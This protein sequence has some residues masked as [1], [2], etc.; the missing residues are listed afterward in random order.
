[1][2]GLTRKETH[3]IEELLLEQRKASLEEAELELAR[4]HDEAPADIVG[5]VAD[6]GDQASAMLLT[7]LNNTMARRHLDEVG[8][9]DAAL[10]HLRGHSFGVCADCGSEIPY[11]RLQA[12][13]TATRCTAC[14]SQ[15]EHLFA[16]GATPTL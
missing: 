11:A 16:H 10:A 1:M 4:V 3:K 5:D 7:D 14:Q 6:E 2:A 8:A 15:R 12:F 13:P 9:I